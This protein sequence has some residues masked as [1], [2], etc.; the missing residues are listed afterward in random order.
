[1][2]I[3]IFSVLWALDIKIDEIPKCG[4]GRREKAIRG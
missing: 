2:E 4:H 3:E 1:M